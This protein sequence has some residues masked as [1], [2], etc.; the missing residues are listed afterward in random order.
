MAEKKKKAPVFTLVLITILVAVV[1][2]SGFKILTSL[3][4]TVD[5]TSTSSKKTV[6]YNGEQYFP[7]QDITVLML[8]GIDEHGAVKASESYNNTGENLSKYDL[9]ACFN[10]Q[11]NTDHRFVTMQKVGNTDYYRAVVPNGYESS[12]NFYLTNQKTFNIGRYCLW[13]QRI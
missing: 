6:E 4:K 9:R 2:F 8:M 3:N 13:H 5:S 12:V 7:R 1:M 10:N 11:A